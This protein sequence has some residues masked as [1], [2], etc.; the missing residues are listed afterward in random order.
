MKL[1]KNLLKSKL[2]DLALSKEEIEIFVYI[3]S[4][5]HDFEHWFAQQSLRFPK[6]KFAFYYPTAIDLYFDAFKL[7]TVFFTKESNGQLVFSQAKMSL[8]NRESLKSTNWAP[9]KEV[10]LS[11][12]EMAQERNSDQQFKKLHALHE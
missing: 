5:R 10:M 4:N 1:L 3:V 9:F 11:Y 7:F 12:L 6:V 2:N 8:L